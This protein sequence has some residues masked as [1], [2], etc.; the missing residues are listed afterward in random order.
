MDKETDGW[1]YRH[2]DRQV[3]RR[4]GKVEGEMKTN[5]KKED[6]YVIKINLEAS[7]NRGRTDAIKKANA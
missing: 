4:V 7:K 6:K 3:G 2:T 5:R 1:I